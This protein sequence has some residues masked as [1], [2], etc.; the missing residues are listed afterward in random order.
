V[1]RR[2]LTRPIEELADVLRRFMRVEALRVL[3]VEADGRLKGPALQTIAGFEHHADNRSPLL[4]VAIAD[5]ADEDA[6][7]EK[8]VAALREAWERKRKAGSPLE[9]MEARPLGEEGAANFSVQLLQLV[10]AVKAPASGIVLVLDLGQHE[11]GAGWRQRIEDMVRSEE[12][13]RVRFV[14][15]S[16]PHAPAQ[17]W[18]G[19]FPKGTAMHHHARANEA[20]AIAELEQEIATEEEL[21]VGMRGAWPRGV[22]VP[23]RPR[24]WRHPA[25]S[26]KPPPPLTL[27]P[28]PADDPTPQAAPADTPELR[29]L[30][31]RAALAMRKGDG[32]E[33][34]RRQTAA[35]ELCVRAGQTRDAVTMEMMLGGYLLALH[36]S[37]LAAEAFG[38]AG[39]MAYEAGHE[40][41]AAEA[42]LA[43]ATT[44]EADEEWVP[45]L[46]A[47]RHAIDSAQAA[48]RVDV[49]LRAYWHAGQ[50]ALR[51]GLEI[52]CI[53][54]YADAV[55]W[56]DNLPPDQRE[57]TR[58]KEIA[59]QLAALLAKHRRYS[60]AREIERMATAF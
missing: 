48:S 38:R 52:D 28:A 31:Q 10:A 50:V 8:S 11:P 44:A 46:E 59:K 20:E 37:R 21:G 26:T 24:R 14:V 15:C 45:A 17:K 3:W 6:A 58:A 41:L 42:F 9:A 43:Q 34:I 33:A 2:S 29:I 40:D 5:V 12:L 22:P 25:S 4:E 7:W 60:E 23:P 35:R 39:V 55:V 16:G 53:G 47:Y 30:V 18:I 19:S 36:Q 27:V 13:A 1:A 57:P 54:L 56:V 51:L 49:C 32:P